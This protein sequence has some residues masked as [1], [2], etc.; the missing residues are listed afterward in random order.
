MA[1]V[2]CLGN[3]ALDANGVDEYASTSE[4]GALS[5]RR[6]APEITSNL[7]CNLDR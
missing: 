5:N 4:P 7:H 1:F 6:T 3:H 2:S